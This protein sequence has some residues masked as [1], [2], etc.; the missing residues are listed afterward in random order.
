M[1]IASYTALLYGLIVIL[2]G[3]MEFRISGSY[4]ALFFESFLG[5]LIFVLAILA[6]NNKKYA[7]YVIAAAALFLMIYYGYFFSLSSNFIP[8]F[9]TAVS[10]YILFIYA[11]K[12][13]K[14]LGSAE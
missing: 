9:L 14:T 5:A 3:C 10:G 4:L 8:G 13:F 6:L 7:V 1:K 11:M 12:I 2:S